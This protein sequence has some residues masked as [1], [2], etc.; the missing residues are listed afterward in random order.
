MTS[1]R[2][3]EDK[4]ESKL[5]RRSNLLDLHIRIGLVFFFFAT[6]M[7]TVVVHAYIVRGRCAAKPGAISREQ[8]GEGGEALSHF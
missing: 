3:A 8:A 1:W 6:F 5:C 4:P 7:T 2:L